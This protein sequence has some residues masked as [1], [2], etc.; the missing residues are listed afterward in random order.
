M[1]LIK[2]KVKVRYYAQLR[3]QL[4]LR[5]E[6]VDLQLPNDEQHLLEQLAALHPQVAVL[7]KSSRIAVEDQYFNLHHCFE[8]ISVVD[9]ISPISGG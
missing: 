6:D 7:F 4:G 8:N 5:E 2:Q 3:E 1:T 9:I